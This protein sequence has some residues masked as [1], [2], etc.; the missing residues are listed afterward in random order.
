[1]TGTLHTPGVYFE[2]IEAPL[3]P[4]L[5][6]LDGAGFVGI[7]ER[8]PL[9]R[10]VEISSFVEY[11]RVFGGYLPHAYLAYAVDGFF[12][13]RG[14][15]CWVVRVDDLITS[16]AASGK[17][18]IE[19]KAFR[20]TAT[21]PGAWGNHIQVQPF[22]RGATWDL[23]IRL[24]EGE[25][26]IVRDLV[27]TDLRKVGRGIPG[28]PLTIT[29]D[30]GRALPG[31][32]R[33]EP[34]AGGADGLRRARLENFLGDGSPPEQP[35]GLACLREVRDAALIALPDLVP[36]PA[37]PD[38]PPPPTP[39]CGLIHAE[40]AYAIS[41]AGSAER[42]AP[43]LEE[44]IAAQRA[45]L[46][47]CA[48]ESDRVAILDMPSALTEEAIPG[49]YLSQV[50]TGDAAVDSYGATFGPWIWADDPLALDGPVRLVP[51]CGHVAGTTAR[52]ERMFG[53]HQPPGNE[54]LEGVRDLAYLIDPAWHG[55]WNDRGGN[56]IRAFAGRG[57]RIFGSRTLSS[58]ESTCFLNVR[59]LLI[60]IRR[61]LLESCNWIPFEPN[62][63]VLWRDVE[64]SV[65][66]FLMDLFERGM[67]DGA[68]AEDAFRV[69][70]DQHT[71]PGYDVD[72]GRL[73]CQ[74]EV[75]LPRAAEFVRLVIEK[76]QEGT[77][78]IEERSVRDV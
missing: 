75:R 57:I 53:L 47:F 31:A 46:A 19:E 62:N 8:G 22:L 69:Q 41:P 38:P 21:S 34:L 55:A 54:V 44:L 66:A 28:F 15:R 18:V 23:H 36:P 17:L 43:Q 67:L 27:N 51:A 2:W 63:S 33:V 3:R 14:V 60:G 9:H 56:A 37:T 50:R 42:P 68:S 35:R 76:T 65:R 26:F 32:P 6:R 1:M 64:R 61:G 59:R 4:R 40:P 7:A 71:N 11:R 12:R 45:V 5:A 74:I 48:Q 16:T 49:R 52:V 20:L 77:E 29:S 30:E 10:A 78:V 25:E 13:N 72:A 39:D 73:Q 58:D 24:R 70:C